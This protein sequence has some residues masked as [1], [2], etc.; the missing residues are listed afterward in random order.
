MPTSPRIGVCSWSIRP[1]GPDELVQRLGQLE[2]P[3]VQLAL[4]PVIAE[5]AV[6]GGALDKLDAAGVRVVSGMLA[7]AGEDYTTLESIR[8]TGGVRPDDTWPA[9]RQLAERVARLAGDAGIGLVTLHAGFLEERAD[10][11]V[12]Q[13]MIERLGVMADVFA[14]HGVDV[15]FET[16]QETAD[17]L[18]GV[19]D[20]LDRS[21]VGVNFDPANMILY[22][23]GEPIEALRELA[24][25]IRQVHVKDALPA[26]RPG[27]WGAEVPAGRGAVAW[28]AFFDAA[29]A[30]EPPVNFV[31]ER[32]AGEDLA[33][34]AAART[35]IESHLARRAVG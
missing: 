31:I 2:I 20:E 7:L 10:D 29:T 32:E 14:G 33:D 35:L 4:A 15:A 34:I 11:P 5:P 1:R 23:M 3:A 22:G 19:L 16:G 12:R 13:V 30:I 25:R 18:Q 28:D 9:N 26:D 27:T 8:R 17:T 21:N 6:W 24:P